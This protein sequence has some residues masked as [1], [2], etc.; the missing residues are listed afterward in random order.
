M[1]GNDGNSDLFGLFGF[2]LG[3]SHSPS[4]FQGFFQVY[5]LQA[6]Y[7]L[8]P[9]KQVDNWKVWAAGS[10]N[11]LGF[12]VT[13]PHKVSILP[14][15]QLSPEAEAI[16]AVNCVALH[17]NEHTILGFGYN[18]DAQGF[19]TDLQAWMPQKPKNALILGNG[20]SA[21]AVSYALT[22]N[23]VPN[24]QVGRIR[25]NASDL[26]WHELEADFFMQFDLIVQSTPLGMWPNTEEQP[27][28]QVDWLL[29]QHFVYDLIY[30]PSPSRFLKQAA[31]RGAQVRD[32]S[33]MLYQQALASLH[34]W[35]PELKGESLN[36]L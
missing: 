10:P 16:G 7:S 22:Q 8:R 34:I 35:K 3:H 18:T 17:R 25:R 27:P 32:G 21:R 9:E 31:A 4:L 13:I 23:Q 20:G 24:L 33:G 30:N 1:S 28:I 2:P 19:W 36:R 11:L 6:E 5:N 15:L 12:N 14:S 29:P 26:L